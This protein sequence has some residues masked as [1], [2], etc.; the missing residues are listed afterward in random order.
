[1]ENY[2][3]AFPKPTRKKKSKVQEWSE[4]RRDLKK[5]YESKGIIQCEIQLSGC[6][7]NNALSF[8]H[9][10]KRRDPRCEHTYQGTLLACIPCHQKIENN[11]ELTEFFFQ[12]LRPDTS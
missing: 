1:M 9:K 7:I 10:F 8:A 4:A 12:K 5:E 3:P 11:K 2:I 6:W